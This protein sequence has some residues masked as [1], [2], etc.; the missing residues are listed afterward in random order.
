MGDVERL[1]E[2]IRALVRERQE[3]RAR[4]ADP[5]ELERN[6]ERIV[7]CQ[8]QLARAYGAQYAPAART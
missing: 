3:L 6:R 8:W 4:G 2:E 7:G 1:N 5:E